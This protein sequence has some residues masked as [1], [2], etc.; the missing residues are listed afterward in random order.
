MLTE[1]P[2]IKPTQVWLLIAAMQFQCSSTGGTLTPCGE[3]ME[4]EVL[5]R[6]K[7]PNLHSKVWPLGTPKR[8]LLICKHIK[9]KE[10]SLLLGRLHVSRH[11]SW[12]KPVSSWF[13][14]HCLGLDL[15]MRLD[16][17]TNQ[18]QTKPF[19]QELD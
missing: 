2:A 7:Q 1:V 3:Q 4:M 8:P 9:Q 15:L 10:G 6:P 12:P 5:S 11:S 13:K 19:Q 17:L 18:G 14:S 16:L